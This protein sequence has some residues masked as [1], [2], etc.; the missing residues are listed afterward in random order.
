MIRYI[1]ECICG[2]TTSIPPTKHW[3]SERDELCQQP[4]CGLFDKCRKCQWRNFL[5]RYCSCGCGNCTIISHSEVEVR[6]GSG[7]DF[8]VTGTS[9]IPKEEQ[10]NPALGEYCRTTGEVEK[11][12]KE[13]GK[14]YVKSDDPPKPY[15]TSE[16]QEAKKKRR[17]FANDA[18][19]IEVKPNE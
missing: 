6:H 18:V 14:E 8:A 3:M 15:E 5:A 4:D 10:W 7:A 17:Q 12:R 1:A 11:H 19:D 2:E 16:S 9:R 13:Q